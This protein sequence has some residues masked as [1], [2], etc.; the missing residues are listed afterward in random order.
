MFL[1]FFKIILV[2]YFVFKNLLYL[3]LNKISILEYLYTKTSW[4]ALFRY[5]I[6]NLRA[7][8]HVSSCY[9]ASSECAINKINI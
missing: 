5:P 2:K 3:V 6:H 9:I 4:I 8:S 1:N 7:I